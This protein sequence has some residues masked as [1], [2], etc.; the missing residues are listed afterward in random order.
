MKLLL[1]LGAHRTGTTALQNSLQRRP[2]M[3]RD[4]GVGFWGPRAMRR[5]RRKAYIPG[6]VG[7]SATRRAELAPVAAE[8]AEAF[9]REKAAGTATLLV[10]DENILGAMRDNY[11][12][13]TLYADAR[14]RLTAAAGLLPE[15][16]ARIFLCV[17]DY[18]DYAVSIHAHLATRMAVGDFDT[19]RL[20]HIGK[21]RG[22]HAV[23]GDIRAVFPDAR[24]SLWRY[25]GRSAAVRG[26]IGV[27]LGPDIAEKIGELPRG[28]S[29]SA[30]R[31]AL[32]EIATLWRDRN[33]RAKRDIQRL[34]ERFRD[35]LPGPRLEPFSL[36]QL[37]ALRA[38][39][40]EDWE[41]LA[42]GKTAGVDTFDPLADVEAAT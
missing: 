16:P 26:S 3:L 40:T 4:A 7:A 21:G 38:R 13:A 20:Q 14:A 9:A 33:G 18:A 42:S 29:R 41:A 36:D 37:A 10:S 31:F 32:V 17:R 35:G 30:S 24:I 5:G 1:H 19:E 27:M 22:W 23:V 25:A 6:M 34:A 28:Q 15:P 39:F 2:R 8:F 12:G 11:R